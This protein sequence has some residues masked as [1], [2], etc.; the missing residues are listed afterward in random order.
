MDMS[1]QRLNAAVLACV[2]IA[3]AAP[4]VSGAFD[5]ET[6]G[7]VYP[8]RAADGDW[9]VVSP[10]SGS[11]TEMH[12]GSASQQA[13][14]VDVTNG[15]TLTTPKR[16]WLGFSFAAKATVNVNGAAWVAEEHVGLG[17]AGSTEATVNVTDGTWSVADSCYIGA[18]SNATG[19]VNLHDGAVWT[20]R[21]YVHV[22]H[23]G[24]G[25][26]NVDPNASWVAEA[27]V[28]VGFF[29]D[30]SGRVNLNGGNWTSQ[31]LTQVGH[32]AGGAVYVNAGSTL[33]SLGPLK[34]TSIGEVTL[35]GGVLHL[36]GG[37]DLTGGLS[38]GAGGGTVRVEVGS[39]VPNSDLCMIGEYVD[40]TGCALEALF[41]P[42]FTPSTSDSFNLFDPISSVDLSAALG[43]ATT[44][45]TPVD[46]QLDPATGVL[47]YIPEPASL[48]LLL[49]G[50][51]AMLRGRARPAKPTRSAPATSAP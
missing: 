37:A 23:Y 29:S 21:D 44:V 18:N 3:A 7:S 42:G 31:A 14:G 6:S 15:A 9:R 32:L 4:D 19:T 33:K 39:A 28:N 13:A 35:A 46:W 25:E 49:L 47:S 5:I 17:N 27:M 38:A 30:S 43:A 36:A 20:S 26:V 45:I 8:S 22:G 50:A 48:T 24:A 40:L 16:V 51:C 41:D 12:V 2:L 11:D 1:I 34:V 10:T